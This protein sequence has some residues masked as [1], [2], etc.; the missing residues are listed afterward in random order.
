MRVRLLTAA[1]TVVAALALAGVVGALAQS[2]G[3]VDTTYCGRFI[4]PADGARVWYYIDDSG[5][6]QDNGGRYFEYAEL[7][8]G[9][10]QIWRT[11]TTDTDCYSARTGPG[12]PTGTPR[13]GYSVRGQR[14]V[15]TPTPTLVPTPTPSPTPQTPTPTPTPSATPQTQTPSPMPPPTDTPDETN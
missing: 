8:S 6:K 11:G 13:D 14:A 5:V 12:T 4:N 3:S 15:P 1:M 2:L 7:P 10:E 9:A